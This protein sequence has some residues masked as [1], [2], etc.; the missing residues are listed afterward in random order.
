MK[1]ELGNPDAD[2]CRDRAK[3]LSLR[4]RFS[5]PPLSESVQTISPGVCSR[6]LKHRRQHP[7][8]R[9]PLIPLIGGASAFFIIIFAVVA[10][11]AI[12]AYETSS[13]GNDGKITPP[14]AESIAVDHPDS[15][16]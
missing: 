2:I 5:E 9:L 7:K 8:N 16:D 10:F 12:R 1:F 13:R 4:N 15:R 11:F 14:V 3:T 6:R